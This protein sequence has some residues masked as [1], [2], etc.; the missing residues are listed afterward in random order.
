MPAC[1]DIVLPCYNPGENWSQELMKFHQEASE[2]YHL[3]YVLVNDGSSSK[4][5]EAII[6]ELQHQ[7]I[8]LKAI[9]YSPNKGKGYALRRGVAESKADYVVY[10]DID[11]PFTNQSM[12]DLMNVLVNEQKDVVAGFRSEAYYQK[13]MTG[14]RVLLSKS[15]RFFLRR[16]VKLPVSDTQCGLKGFNVKGREKFLNTTINRYLFDF[17]F[18]Y[19]SCRDST[20][21]MATVEVTLKEN[22]VF[23]SMKLKILF[24][25]TLNL[26]S[27]LLF[28]R[29]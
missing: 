11:F 22:V 23:R 17:E 26:F 6:R 18:I 20:L 3:Q 14:F 7:K 13:N 28:K 29:T 2:T 8:P 4:Q 19:T 24:Q 27:V 12:M 16:I 21:K 10:T 15:F 1:V 25:E 5:L 9:S